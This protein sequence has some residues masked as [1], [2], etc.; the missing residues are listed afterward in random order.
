MRQ[1]RHTQLELEVSAGTGPADVF[2]RKRNADFHIC[3]NGYYM[4][5]NEYSD[6]VNQSFIVRNLC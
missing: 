5:G 4:D 1:T 3:S 2:Y 6:S